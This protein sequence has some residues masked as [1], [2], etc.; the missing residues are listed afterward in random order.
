MEK[1]INIELFAAIPEEILVKILQYVSI[2][3]V[4]A[5][6]SVNKRLNALMD[7]N[8]KKDILDN[9]VVLNKHENSVKMREKWQSELIKAAVAQDSPP[10]IELFIKNSSGGS[11]NTAIGELIP[12]A[13]AISSYEHGT[14]AL[15]PITFSQL[16]V[17][18]I[19]KKGLANLFKW[20][21]EEW[22]R[23]WPEISRRKHSQ[24]F[25]AFWLVVLHATYESH[26][27]DVADFQKFSKLVFGQ[28]EIY[29]DMLLRLLLS[30]IGSFSVG[31]QPNKKIVPLSNLLKLNCGVYL[32]FLSSLRFNAEG[33]NIDFFNASPHCI[34]TEDDTISSTLQKLMTLRPIETSFYTG[35]HRDTML[36][37]VPKIHYGAIFA[38][39]L[40]PGGLEE[41]NLKNNKLIELGA[42][43]NELLPES[44]SKLNSKTHRVES[45]LG[46]VCF[47]EIPRQWRIEWLLSNGA[48]FS[49]LETEY[50]NNQENQ[51]WKQ[52][53]EAT[54]KPYNMLANRNN[55][56]TY[57]LIG[58]YIS[59][60]SS[61]TFLENGEF[62]L[63]GYDKNSY[64]GS[65]EIKGSLL[66]C[67]NMR[68]KVRK[69]ATFMPGVEQVVPCELKLQFTIFQTAT[70]GVALAL[71]E[72]NM[73]Q[74]PRPYSSFYQFYW[75]SVGVK[76]VP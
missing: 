53:L 58:Q 30:E 68:Q 38:V 4:P 6:C 75:S 12:T 51:H 49:E 34:L 55:N 7:I 46:V 57:V 59:G 14:S 11:L 42:D 23:A 32:H 43:I 21:I 47:A 62:E 27:N 9:Y 20:M 10:H 5:V 2:A 45:A 48:K 61:I 41:T 39:S 13:R 25:H 50:I 52:I 17:E 60:S 40:C 31:S 26:K 65:F 24:S 18:N 36:Q 1:G 15:P 67:F 22:E 74:D 28:I 37:F 63:T 76:R 8:M 72:G 44:F 56:K 64:V 35:S 54:K 19:V 3:D 66:L 33:V 29:G 70:D 73:T 16:F 71:D 69:L